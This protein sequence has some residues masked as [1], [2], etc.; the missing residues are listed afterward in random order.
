MGTIIACHNI[1]QTCT[2]KYE[3][4]DV[5][6]GVVASELYFCPDGPF[7]LSIGKTVRDNDINVVN[8]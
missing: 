8:Y 3:D 5:S 2:V 4:G 7:D 6:D 1:A